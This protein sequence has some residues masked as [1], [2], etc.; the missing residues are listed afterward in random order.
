MRTYEYCL[1]EH[2]EKRKNEH[3][4]KVSFFA[5]SSARSSCR[6]SASPCSVCLAFFVAGDGA[7]EVAGVVFA[8][9]TAFGLGSMLDKNAIETHPH[10]YNPILQHRK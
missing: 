7:G 8:A 10:H 4:Q 5:C 6:V 9:A 2:D 3:R 1:L